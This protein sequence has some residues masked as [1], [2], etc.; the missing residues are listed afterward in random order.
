MVRKSAGTRR[1]PGETCAGRALE[2]KGRGHGEGGVS[3]AAEAVS[4]F[5]LTH[6]YPSVLLEQAAE[7]FTPDLRGL[8]LLVPN[9]QARRNLHSR[10]RHAGPA[11]TLTQP[12]REL[13]RNVG[14]TPLRAGDRDTFRGGC[15]AA[16]Q[17]AP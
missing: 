6:P 11:Q 17:K 15:D 5:V 7:R 16:V 12:A 2:K 3:R 14:W 9:V 10:P 4:R 1:R 8:R 13:L